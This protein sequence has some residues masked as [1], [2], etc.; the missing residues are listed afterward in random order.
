MNVIGTF[1]NKEGA[2][3]GAIG[4]DKQNVKISSSRNL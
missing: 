4:Y 2:V 1:N 3:K